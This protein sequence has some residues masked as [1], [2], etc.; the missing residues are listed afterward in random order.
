[1]P[2]MDG[3]EATRA[4]KREHAEVSILIVTTQE[5]QNYLLRP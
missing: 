2:V 5:S 1:M 3:L 4:I